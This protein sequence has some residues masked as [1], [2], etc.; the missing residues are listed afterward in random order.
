MNV[1]CHHC[2]TKLNIPDHKIPK[3]KESTVSCPKC[4]EKIVIHAAKSLEKTV[5]TKKQV[6]WLGFEDRLNALVC[7]GDDDLHQKATQVLKEIGF[8]VKAAKDAKTAINKMGY[9]IYHL[10]LMD[11]TFDQNQGMTQI[12]DRLNTM[13]MSLR[14]RICLLLLSSRFQT[15]DN[16]AALHIS[17]NNILNTADIF[18]IESFLTKAVTDHKNL[19]TVYNESLK[20]AGKA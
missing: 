9:H 15:N 8:D 6:P 14:R 1:I 17:V 18:H 5:E 2:K 12:I 4:R 20:L 13:D 11:E 3:D 19:Y 7:V 10:V 16:M